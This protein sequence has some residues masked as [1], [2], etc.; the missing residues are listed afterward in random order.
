MQSILTLI[1]SSLVSVVGREFL[2]GRDK[3]AVSDPS[4]VE[5]L[6]IL[7]DTRVRTKEGM[8]D[9]QYYEGF[10]RRGLVSRRNTEMVCTR[11]AFRGIRG[12]SIARLHQ[13]E[14]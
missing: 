13:L 12:V 11:C 6:L 10:G 3:A 7:S 14:V 4:S 8:S 9:N 5:I 2:Q 1:C